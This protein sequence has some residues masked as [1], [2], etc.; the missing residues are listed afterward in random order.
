MAADVI[1]RKI[2]PVCCKQPHVHVA[3]FHDFSS[4]YASFNAQSC[5][6]C[7]SYNANRL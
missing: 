1:E 5:A 3:A 2:F 4:V 7:Q 6:M